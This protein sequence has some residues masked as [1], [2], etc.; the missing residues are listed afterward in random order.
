MAQ[1]KAMRVSVVWCLFLVFPPVMAIGQDQPTELSQTNARDICSSNQAVRLRAFVN[2]RRLG[3]PKQREAAEILINLLNPSNEA[4]CRVAAAE[5]LER[6]GTSEE[7]KG[8]VDPLVLMLNDQNPDLQA[9]GADALGYMGKNAS[10]ALPKLIALLKNPKSELVTSTVEYAIGSIAFDIRSKGEKLP[11][12]R[13]AV[14]PLLNRLSEVWPSDRSSAQFIIHLYVR[15]NA[16]RA[17]GLIGPD[18]AIAVDGLRDALSDN[19]PIYWELR[20]RS[21]EALGEIGP[22]AKGAAPNLIRALHDAEPKVRRAAADSLG[23]ISP[24]PNATIQTLIEALN[25]PGAATSA[26]ASL[27][28]LADQAIQTKNFDAIEDLTKATE[29]LSKSDNAEVRRLAASEASAVNSLESL[30]SHEKLLEYYVKYHWLLLV[31]LAYLVLLLVVLFVFKFFPLSLLIINDFLAQ[32]DFKVPLAGFTVPVRQVLLV[33]VFCYRPRVLDVWIQKRLNTV[34]RRFAEKSTVVKQNIHLPAPIGL[35]SSTLPDILVTDIQPSFLSPVTRILICG[36]PGTGKTNIACQMAR[37]ALSEESV[38]WLN[39]NHPT[40]PVLL[41]AVKLHPDDSVKSLIDSVSEQLQAMTE[42]ITQPK[43]DLVR[44]LLR[45]GR[46]L[47]VLDDVSSM[48]EVVRKKLFRSVFDVPVNSVVITS[49]VDYSLDLD[50]VMIRPQPIKGDSLARFVDAYFQ[51]KQVRECFDDEEFFEACKAL[52]SAEGIT[53]LVARDLLDKM[54]T[55]TKPL[56]GERKFY[57]RS[58]DPKTNL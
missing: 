46:I 23:K 39:P 13:T 14:D 21:V 50:V 2:F 24:N 4:D 22:A 33:R 49:R 18:S 8:A 36:E 52:S 6:I 53:P 10:D 12:L 35:N 15:Q 27:N 32:L 48:D 3:E 45:N 38:E 37:W 28:R 34:R 17:L 56:N 44:E 54:I 58:E 19:S 11:I 9:A 25:D 40:M 26:A 47:L 30:R 20:M 55:D 43:E 16:A 57:S 41:E 42:A 5:S 31:I 7:A 29:A 51:D 1:L